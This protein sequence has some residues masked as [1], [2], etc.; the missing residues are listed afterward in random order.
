M[1]PHPYIINPDIVNKIQCHPYFIFVLSMLLLS[2]LF[3]LFHIVRNI[4]V[5]ALIVLYY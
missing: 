2:C 1:T 3:L 4:I 5:I